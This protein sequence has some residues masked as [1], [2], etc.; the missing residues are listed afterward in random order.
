VIQSG[1]LLLLKRTGEKH[2]PM[3]RRWVLTDVGGAAFSRRGRTKFS[4]LGQAAEEDP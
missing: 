4:F 3:H 1:R 2:S